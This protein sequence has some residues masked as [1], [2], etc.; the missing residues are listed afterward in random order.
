MAHTTYE[1]NRITALEVDGQAVKIASAELARIQHWV[2]DEPSHL[3]WEVAGRT[4]EEMPDGVH[5][6]AMTIGGRRLPQR[7]VFRESHA[8]GWTVFKIVGL[9]ELGPVP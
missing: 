2:D 4:Q 3:E 7:G 5:A 8:D 9:D 6:F 1:H